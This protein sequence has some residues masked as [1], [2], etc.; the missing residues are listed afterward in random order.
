MDC[1]PNPLPKLEKRLFQIAEL[2]PKPVKG[3]YLK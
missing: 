1:T 2:L 3:S